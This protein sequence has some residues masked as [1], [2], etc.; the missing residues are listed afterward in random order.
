MKNLNSYLRGGVRFPTGGKGAASRSPRTRRVQCRADL[1]KFQSR[2]YSAAVRSVRMK[3]DVRS[4]LRMFRPIM[5]GISRT[6]MG[7]FA[8]RNA[9][10]EVLL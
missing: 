1:V 6:V 4:L 10:N 8:P 9:G 5:G 2:R 7:F 3:E